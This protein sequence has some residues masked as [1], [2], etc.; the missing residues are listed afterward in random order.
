MRQVRPR[1]PSED[2]IERLDE[3]HLLAELAQH[4]GRFEADIATTDHRHALD[5]REL[6]EH[7]IDVRPAADDMNSRQLASLAAKPARLAARGPDQPIVS[8]A[9]ACFR[10]EDLRARIDRDDPSAGY[11]LHLAVRPEAGGS[12]QKPVERLLAGEILLRERRAFV[13][14]LGFG[15]DQSDRAGEAELAELDRGL[16]PAMA[17]AHDRDV[18]M[19]HLAHLPVRCRAS[20]GVPGRRGTGRRRRLPQPE[21]S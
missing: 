17:G 14:K 13:G 18:E 4:G 21:R 12:D 19:L 6:R 20:H 2:P 9:C 1:D 3:H 8:E 16:R 5:G 15:A 10:R 11:Q 7:P